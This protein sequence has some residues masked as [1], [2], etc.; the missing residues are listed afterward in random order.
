MNMST[1]TEKAKTYG[2]KDLYILAMGTIESIS[3]NDYYTP[4]A[5]V[6]LIQETINSLFYVR[7]DESLPWHETRKPSARTESNEIFTHDDCITAFADME[8]V[9]TKWALEE[10]MR[11]EG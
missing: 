2:R 10:I 3:E 6:N 9:T 8:D 7:A 11:Q 5:K 4:E 1:M